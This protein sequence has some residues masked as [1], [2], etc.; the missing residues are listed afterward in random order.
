MRDAWSAEAVALSVPKEPLTGPCQGQDLVY[1]TNT[2]SRGRR[3][4]DILVC[5]KQIL[6]PNL[7]PAKFKVDAKSKQVVQPEGIPLVMNPYD[8]QAVELALRLKEKHNG[9][10]TV[11]SLGS[12]EAISAIRHALSLGADEGIAL[13][14]E[15]FAGSDSFSIAYILSNAI[16]KVGSYD[17]VLC[18]REAA[19][20]DEGLTGPVLAQKLGIPLVS[21]VKDIDIADGQLSLTRVISGGEQVFTVPMPALA[22]VTNEAPQP[23]LPSGWGIISASRKEIPVWNAQDIGADPSEVGGN[24]ARRSLADLSIP[25]R[26]R[27]C[28]MVDGESTSEAAGKLAERLN[29]MGVIL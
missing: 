15:A 28:E 26:K 10:V 23:R 27:T 24:A 13:S 8:E 3:T 18:G 17:L 11:L 22:T 16:Q 14:D 29:E 9:K 2:D 21:L 20:W 12:E 4:M 25:Q 6:D 1:A 19:D 5:V 7:P